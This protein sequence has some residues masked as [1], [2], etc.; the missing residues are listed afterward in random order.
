[1][2]MPSFGFSDFTL[3][4]LPK[5]NLKVLE[6]AVKKSWDPEMATSLQKVIDVFTNKLSAYREWQKKEA[7]FQEMYKQFAMLSTQFSN[8]EYEAEA[9][10]MAMKNAS[11][12]IPLYEKAVAMEAP[13]GNFL[14]QQLLILNCHPQGNCIFRS[15]SGL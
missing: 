9:A 6:S 7:Y 8:L 5:D 12:L 14:G 2:G 15:N 1:M 10:N 3:D 11:E 4:D 13:I